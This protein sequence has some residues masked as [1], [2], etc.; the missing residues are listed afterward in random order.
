MEYILSLVTLM[1]HLIFILLVH[2]LLVMLFDWS[3]LVKNPQDK[4]G[5]LR[6]F[7]I[8]VSM[9]V[10]Y[11]VSHFMLEVLSIIQTAILGQ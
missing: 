9:A 4:V 2:R 10:G 6:V 5:Q 3:K 11:M 8:L 1:S 7:L